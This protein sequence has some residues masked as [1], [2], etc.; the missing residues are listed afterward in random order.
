MPTD[1][2]PIKPITL[3]DGAVVQL[4]ATYTPP[5][6]TPPP[7]AVPRSVR[8]G[9]GPWFPL[10]AVNPSGG[11]FA[12]RGPGQLV[13][14][15]EASG[16]AVTRTNE[17]GAELPVSAGGVA[18]TLNDRQP[19][20]VAAGTL[21]PA[22]GL[23]LSGH[24]VA[25]DYLLQWAKPGAVVQL[26]GDPAPTNPTDPTPPTAGGYPIRAVS[27]YKMMYNTSPA[28]PLD[29]AP[30]E[31][32]VVRLAFATGPSPRLLGYGPEGEQR[33]KSTLA[34]WTASGRRV[35]VSCGGSGNATSTGDRDGFMKGVKAIRADLGPDNCHG[36]DWDI[37]KGTQTEDD[38]YALSMNMKETFGPSWS[39]G[40]VPGDIDLYLRVAARLAKAGALDEYGQQF[41]DA[42]V[43]EQAMMGRLDQAVNAGIPPERISI[44]MMIAP[45][46]KHWSNAV[47]VE[48]LAAARAKYRGL[49]KVY[50]WEG[51]RAGTAQWCRDMAAGI[52]S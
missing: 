32:N 14:F 31:C 47:C 21:I 45:D 13:L 38:L 39:I 41:Y 7:V 35:V 8:V 28:F 26:S 3:P 29:A 44:G 24:G 49:T 27:V 11:P 18:Q 36:W 52:S 1:L 12:G 37:E 4:S 15:D 25:R 23:V 40:F 20:R 2:D 46:E 9:A 33:F 51:S 43:T 19:G 6:V 42:V 10:A 16:S 34:A 22:R 30:P 17:W 5:T 50:L 48:R